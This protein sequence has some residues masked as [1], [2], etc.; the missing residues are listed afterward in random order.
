MHCQKPVQKWERERSWIT[1]R[2]VVH[3]GARSDNTAFSLFGKNKT[4]SRSKWLFWCQGEVSCFGPT[5]SPSSS[6]W[7]LL[8][9]SSSYTKPLS[10]L[11]PG[12]S[13]R[14]WRGFGILE[15]L[16]FQSSSWSSQKSSSQSSIHK[17]HH[18]SIHRA[19]WDFWRILDCMCVWLKIW[20]Y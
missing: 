15:F 20:K 5:P 13:N 7:P 1:A 11:P 12:W 9:C 17:N 6:Q 2:S 8:S 10:P 19:C 14:I 4:A 16:P 3:Y 18:H